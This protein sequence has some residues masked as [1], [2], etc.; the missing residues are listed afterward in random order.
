[1]PHLPVVN[2]QTIS[3]TFFMKFDQLSDKKV[4]PDINSSQQLAK[5]KGLDLN[6]IKGNMVE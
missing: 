3:I 2:C 4:S 5:D 1:M 6:D